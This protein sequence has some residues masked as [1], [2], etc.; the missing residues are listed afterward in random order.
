MIA[1]VL[2][3]ILI[4]H[5]IIVQFYTVITTD[6]ITEVYMV[7]ASNNLVMV[8]CCAQFF[9]GKFMNTLLIKQENSIMFFFF[10]IIHHVKKDANLEISLETS[11]S[12]TATELEMSLI[13]ISV[14]CPG[15]LASPAT[16]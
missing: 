4:C 5:L 15:I 7:F 1:K 6:I 8:N 14:S 10:L 3:F 2:D 16:Q 11:G 9:F 12:P 13:F